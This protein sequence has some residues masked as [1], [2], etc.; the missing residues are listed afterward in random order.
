MRIFAILRVK[1]HLKHQKLLSPIPFMSLAE[2]TDQKI[3]FDSALVPWQEA[4]VHVLSHGLHYGTSIFEGLRCYATEQG[5][6]IFRLREHTE[7]LLHSAHIIGMR[8]PYSLEA[9]QEAHL[10]VVA[11]NALTSCYIRPLAFYGA[12][13]LGIYAQDNPVHVAIAAWEWGT[14]LGEEG[15]AKGIRV[16]TSS[17][18][19]MHI[20]ANMCRAKVGGNYINSVMAHSEVAQDGYEEALLLD[21]SGLVAEGAGENLFIVRRGKIYTPMLTSALDG[22]TR[23]TVL[24]L[25]QDLGYEVLERSI[26]RDALYCADEAFFTGTAAEVTPIREVDNRQIGS[27]TR[28][29][30]TAALQQAFFQLVQGKGK[31]SAAWLTPVPAA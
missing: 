19:R 30:V 15:L 25:A 8:I 28:G 4:T 7:R 31:H 24:T 22:I 6:A 27:G 23:D 17:F 29:P 13:T 11:A 1:E 3:W 20:N 5:A 26:T 12:K 16:K 9:L 14:Y 18:T 2:K 10:Q 21:A